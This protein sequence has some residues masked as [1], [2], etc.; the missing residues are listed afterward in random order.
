MREY[1]ERV[2]KCRQALKALKASAKKMQELEQLNAAAEKKLQLTTKQL[3]IYGGAVAMA[4]ELDRVKTYLEE[5]GYAEDY[6]NWASDYETV[7]RH[8]QE[9]EED[10]YI[11]AYDYGFER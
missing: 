5:R 6:E 8:E 2:T 3:Q 10:D 11:G 9:Q 1:K 4:K 7:R